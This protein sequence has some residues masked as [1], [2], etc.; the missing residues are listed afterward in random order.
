MNGYPHILKH[1]C[2]AADFNHGARIDKVRCSA[3]KSGRSTSEVAFL[4]APRQTGWMD[5]RRTQEDTPLPSPS[6]AMRC[7]GPHRRIRQRA[8][9]TPVHG[10]LNLQQC[11]C[12]CSCNCNCKQRSPSSLPHQARQ[13]H[14]ARQLINWGS[15]DNSELC[16]NI[17][18]LR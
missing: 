11:S 5:G 13:G 2:L 14:N 9:A 4:P 18:S 1:A 7:P 12:S 17:I 6:T 16:T 3:V 15:K 8:S 10:P